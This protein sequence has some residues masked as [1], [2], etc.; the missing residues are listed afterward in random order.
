MC[1][2]SSLETP[3]EASR[4]LAPNIYRIPQD[5]NHASHEEE[6]EEEEED[7]DKDEEEED[8]NMIH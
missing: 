1:M 7:E 5:A 8:A 6:E 3:C 2:S 4:S